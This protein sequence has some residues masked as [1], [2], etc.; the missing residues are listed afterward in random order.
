MENFTILIFLC[1]F[2]LPFFGIFSLYMLILILKEDY[3][4]KKILLISFVFWWAVMFPVLNFT[5]NEIINLNN[6][7]VQFKSLI[8]EILH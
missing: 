4:R 7:N 3:M 8:V 2:I 5:E 1:Q 6:N